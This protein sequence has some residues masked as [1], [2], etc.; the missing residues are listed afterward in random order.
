[1]TH[2]TEIT[3][4]S[5]GHVTHARSYHERDGHHGHHASGHHGHSSHSSHSHHS[6]PQTHK[7]THH[8]STSS[9]SSNKFAGSFQLPVSSFTA[10]S[11]HK[12]NS[13]QML[14]TVKSCDKGGEIDKWYRTLKGTKVRQ[15]EV[16]K[17]R[18]MATFRHEFVLVYLSDGNAYR[19]DRRP[20]KAPATNI[21]NVLAG[22]KAEDSMT[23]VTASELK[24]L[25]QTSDTVEQVHFRS[26]SKPDIRNVIVFSAFLH[27][28]RDTKKYEMVGHNC[29]FFA[30]SVVNF[31]TSI[32][33]K[34]LQDVERTHCE[35]IAESTLKKM[36]K[37]DFY[38]Q[39]DA[40]K[41]IVRNL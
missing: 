29:Y 15:I 18:D 26:D 25:Q 5:S 23:P 34:H 8:S 30:R 3:M 12:H 13:R 4:D 41:K 24:A 2:H 36:L 7:A 11:P 21:G 40:S 33:N 39:F 37:H 32:K 6:H 27:G 1:M 14:I 35:S 10:S 22:C 9:S 17:D 16:R 28:N 31:V 19:F 38:L 20:H